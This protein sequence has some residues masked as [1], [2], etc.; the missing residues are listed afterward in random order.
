ML[1]QNNKKNTQKLFLLTFRLIFVENTS[2]LSH[3]LY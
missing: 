2:D 3:E 1:M